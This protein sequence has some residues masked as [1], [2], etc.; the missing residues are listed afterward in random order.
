MK[1]LYDKEYSLLLK[2]RICY[3]FVVLFPTW[4]HIL[5]VPKMKW[6]VRA[7]VCVCLVHVIF[8]PFQF[9]YL[10]Q[11]KWLI[12]FLLPLMARRHFKC[13]VPFY[14]I[15]T[16]DKL[17]DKYCLIQ[18]RR[19]QNFPRYPCNWLALYRNILFSVR[20]QCTW[21]DQND[22]KHLACVAWLSDYL[23]QKVVFVFL[24]SHFHYSMISIKITYSNIKEKAQ[25][26]V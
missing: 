21:N 20:Y 8:S 26:Y 11:R 22:G 1:S 17:S 10:Y 18:Y 15:S 19:M 13:R 7:C 23:W 25:M 2:F 24:S 12:P 5:F 3:T 6:N 4:K 16:Y 9:M 14:T